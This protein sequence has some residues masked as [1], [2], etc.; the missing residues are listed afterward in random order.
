MKRTLFD[1]DHDEFR[2]SVQTFVAGPSR[3]TATK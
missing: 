3:P 1:E 2:K